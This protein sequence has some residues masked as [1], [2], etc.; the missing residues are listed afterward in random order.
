[1]FLS[2]KG[3]NCTA[4]KP[5]SIYRPASSSSDKQRIMMFT[6]MIFDMAYAGATGFRIAACVLLSAAANIVGCLLPWYIGPMALTISDY[7]EDVSI[8]WGVSSVC[9]ILS[10]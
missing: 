2:T 7:E 9:L 6:W 1:M 4:K 8:S 3:S 10:A 5:L